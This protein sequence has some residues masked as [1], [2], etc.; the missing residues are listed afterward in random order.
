MIEVPNA[1]P[2]KSPVVD[3]IVATAVLLLVHVPPVD[4][5]VR[6]V[7]EPLHTV[8]VPAIAAG[9]GFTVTIVVA[10]PQDVV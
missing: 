5:L 2:V 9:E 6:V 10:V 7:V 3:P 4:E 1:T 8:V